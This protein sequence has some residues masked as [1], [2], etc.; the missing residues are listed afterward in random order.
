MISSSKAAGREGLNFGAAILPAVL[1]VIGIVCIWS[2]IELGFTQNHLPGPGF[3]PVIYGILMVLCA[4]PVTLS[5]LRVGPADEGYAKP[6]LLAGVLVMTI[7][8]FG[9]IGGIGSLFLMMF[10]LFV[11]LERLPPL[12]SLLI[13]AAGAAL[14]Y[15]IFVRALSVAL[16]NGPWGF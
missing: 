16:P 11:L 3:M 13:S 15:F 9:I 14:F 5:E 1:L 12:R 10:G 6:L 2:G 7:I 8:G 4:V